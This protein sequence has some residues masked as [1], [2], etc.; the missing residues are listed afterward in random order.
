MFYRFL[1]MNKVVYNVKLVGLEWV[2]GPHTH[3]NPTNLALFR[4]K[5]TLYRFSQGGSYYCRGGMLQPGFVGCAHPPA[6]QN[7][8]NHW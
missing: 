4:H 1:T 2:W 5:I 6:S 7:H 8:F 3:S